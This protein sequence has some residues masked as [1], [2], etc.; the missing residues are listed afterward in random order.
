MPEVRLYREKVAQALREAAQAT[1]MAQRSRLID[2]A[3]LWNRHAD[4]LEA[5][6]PTPVIEAAPILAGEPPPVAAPPD[7]RPGMVRSFFA[8]VLG[9]R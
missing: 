4:D 5:Q 8:M 6:R 7:R 2:Q 3:A 9:R 1:N